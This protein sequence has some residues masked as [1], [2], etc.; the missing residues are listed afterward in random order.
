MLPKMDSGWLKIFEQKGWVYFALFLFFAALRYLLENALLPSLASFTWL[1]D[2]SLLGAVLFAILTIGSV[3]YSIA[4]WLREFARSRRYR[5]TVLRRL[6][7]LS[8][9]EHRILSYLVQSNSQS[10]NYRI[11]DGDVQ[12]LVQKG[13]LEM[14]GGH[15]NIMAIPFCVPDFVWAQL[16]KRSHEFSSA[17]PP[18]DEPWVKN[19]MAY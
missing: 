2:V 15:Q 3:G 1:S 16:K 13:L 19:W 17:A 9:I 5:N 11:D 14:A 8:D 18:E 6:D 7:S 10:F 12:Q 4:T